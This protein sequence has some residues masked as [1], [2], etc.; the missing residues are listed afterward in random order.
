MSRGNGN[1]KSPNAD[2]VEALPIKELQARDEQIAK[3]QAEVLHL[4][5]QLRA[6]QKR[7]D[8]T[9]EAL[10]KLGRPI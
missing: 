3:L 6:L 1:R 2:H 7:M 8:Y 5:Q 10:A 9:A 4:Q